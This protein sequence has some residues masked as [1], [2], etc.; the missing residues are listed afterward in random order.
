[1]L[2]EKGTPLIMSPA[3]LQRAR[4]M[5]SRDRFSPDARPLRQVASW[6][7]VYLGYVVFYSV[8][9][10]RRQAAEFGANEVGALAP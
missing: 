2:L 8:N 4:S 7:G 3:A 6:L 5:P 1:M 9:S 10:A